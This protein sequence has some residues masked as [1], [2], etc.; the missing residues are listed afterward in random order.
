MLKLLQL[1]Q[2]STVFFG[3]ETLGVGGDDA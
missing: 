3:L 2:G 1:G